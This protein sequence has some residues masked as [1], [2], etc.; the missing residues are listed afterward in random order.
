MSDCYFKWWSQ[1]RAY[2][3]REK[4]PTVQK[5]KMLI[6][7]KISNFIPKFRLRHQY[8]LATSYIQKRKVTGFKSLRINFWEIN[9]VTSKWFFG[10]NLQKRSK[11]KKKEHHHRI[12]HIQN[13]LGTKFQLKLTILDFW[14]KL[15]Q[16][17]YFQ[18]KEE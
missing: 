16:K 12:S 1:P 17:R 13:S 15:S 8:I 10:Q 14:T 5:T 9:Q 3:A 7:S 18:P 4:R 6:F 2:V 11:T